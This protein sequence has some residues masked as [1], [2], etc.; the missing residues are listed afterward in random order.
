M[1]WL[2]IYGT[3]VSYKKSIEPVAVNHYTCSRKVVAMKSRRTT[4]PDAGTKLR[5]VAYCRVS[6]V[7]QAAEGVSLDAQDAA[8]RAYCTFR[9]LDL[10]DVVVDAG[11]SA[12]KP[13]AAREG[14]RRVLDLVA[15]G[16]VDA[17]VAL[18]LDRLFRDCADCLTV[19]D[20]WDR[21]GVSLHLVD[22]GGQT[23][24]TSTA[25]GRFFLTVMAGA[26]EME[27]N[28]VRERTAGALQHLRAQGVQ[29]GGEALGWTRDDDTDDDG[30]KVVRKVAAECETV[31]RILDLRAEG[32]TLQAIADTLTAE[33]RPTK[34]GGNWYPATV[35]NVLVREGAAA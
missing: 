30:R 35:R 33:G 24:D 29:L 3:F 7:E 6:T 32:L 31:A 18:K 19:T 21:D 25:M 12:G 13:L 5:A 10:V 28:L 1:S 2:R 11:I 4:T 9:G 17:V 16:D 8:L 23:I 26:A 15:D 27:R 22:M 20:L 14:G 34:R